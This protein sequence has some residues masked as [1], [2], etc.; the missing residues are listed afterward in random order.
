MIERNP[1]PLLVEPAR[2]DELP[3][4]YSLAVPADVRQAAAL[5]AADR[6]AQDVVGARPTLGGGVG[7]EGARGQRR[8]GGGHHRT[9]Q[10]LAAAEVAHRSSVRCPQ[11]GGTPSKKLGDADGY[12]IAPPPDAPGHERRGIGKLLLAYAEGLAI[13]R[14]ATALRIACEERNRAARDLYR[15]LGFVPVAH[16]LFERTLPGRS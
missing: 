1:T 2:H 15:R 3:L 16:E 8:G 11:K 9:L 5:H 13:S 4:L 12:T 7:Q 10:E 14:Q 6:D